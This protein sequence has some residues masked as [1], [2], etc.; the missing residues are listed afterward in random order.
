MKLTDKLL[1]YLYML[2]EFLAFG[3]KNVTILVISIGS[4]NHTCCLVDVL[5]HLYVLCIHSALRSPK[6]CSS[7]F[8]VY[9]SLCYKLFSSCLFANTQTMQ[10][11]EFDQCVLEDICDCRIMVIFLILLYENLNICIRRYL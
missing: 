7:R 1:D 6:A 11:Q 8:A 2:G 5:L 9:R 3:L 10:S 4:E